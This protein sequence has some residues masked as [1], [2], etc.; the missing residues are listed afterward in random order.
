MRR[1]ITIGREFGSGGRELGRWLSEKLQIT[2]YDQEIMTE[3][4]KRTSIPEEYVQQIEESRPIMS[5]PIQVGHSFYPISN[6]IFQQ[7]ISI[8]TEQHKLLQELAAKSDCVIVGRCADFVLK[9]LNPVRIF[10][11][12][13][14][15]SKIQ[16]CMERRP[17][18]ENLTEAQ[19]KKKIS[20]I[21]R[22]RAKYYEFFTRKTWGGRENYDLL[23]NT[24]GEIGRA[25]V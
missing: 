23:I 24:Y 10:V 5:F 3:I 13:D 22:G 15:E 4:S 20:E 17:E 7:S 9:D 2:Y 19:M 6:Q 8:Y 1:I 14:L 21:D 25:H 18:G 16:R 11:Y 12:A